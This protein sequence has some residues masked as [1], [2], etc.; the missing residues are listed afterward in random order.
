VIQTS[1]LKSIHSKMS[2][3]YEQIREAMTV[4]SILFQR[5]TDD[6]TALNNASIVTLVFFIIVCRLG[7]ALIS[8]YYLRRQG[9]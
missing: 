6:S 1:G 9:G 7:D 2:E 5:A 8:V 4:D 3:D